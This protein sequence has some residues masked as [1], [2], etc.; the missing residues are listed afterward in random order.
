MEPE[1]R[2]DP[3]HTVFPKVTKCTFHKYAATGSVEDH[4]GL[5]VLSLN[6]INEKIFIMLWFWLVLLATTDFYM[7]FYRMVIIRVTQAR[8][9]QLHVKVRRSCKFFTAREYCH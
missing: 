2:L 9:F 1:D 4:D 5:C 3:M 6:V 8:V 7:L